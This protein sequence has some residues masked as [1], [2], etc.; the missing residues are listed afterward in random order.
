MWEAQERPAEEVEPFEEEVLI[1]SA[2]AALS[3]CNQRSNLEKPVCSLQ[4]SNCLLFKWPLYQPDHSGGQSF[5]LYFA[6]IQLPV[7]IMAQTSL[8]HSSTFVIIIT[9]I[10][11]CEVYKHLA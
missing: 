5:S 3:N 6:E 9:D 11:C 7:D 1:E 2:A 8:S 10:P 4:I